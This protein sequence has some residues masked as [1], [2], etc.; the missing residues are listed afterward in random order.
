VVFSPVF[1]FPNK[2]G[3][4]M[5]T[6]TEVLSKMECDDLFA[7]QEN[8][9][10]TPP[11]ADKEWSPSA[12][13]K[14][15]AWELYTE[16]RTRI[17]TQPLAYRH[18]DEE[19]ALTSVYK[20]FDLTRTAI[21]RH[22]DCTHFAT[23]A[24]HVLNVHIRPFTAYWHKVKV[25]G[26]LGNSDTCHRF[27]R[28][29]AELQ[30]KLRLFMRLL[31]HLAEGDEFTPGTESGI[32]SAVVYP[33][34]DLGSALE[35]GI[36]DS[37]VPIHNAA[38]IDQRERDEVIARRRTYDLSAPSGAP[39]DAD[40]PKDAVGLAIS[41]GGIR[42]AT[43]SLGVVQYL[44]RKG[45]I[46]AVDFMSTVSGGGY[47][48]S[49][50]SSFLNDPKSPNDPENHD[51]G[52]DPKRHKWP[53][54][55]L[56]DV[57]S[58]AIRHLRNHSKYLAE[59]G[60][61]TYA[62]VLGQMLYGIAVNLFLTLP[63][64]LLAVVVA[65]HTLK[66]SFRAVAE[67]GTVHYPS[68]DMMAWV[69][70]VAVLLLASIVVLPVVQNTGRNLGP[71]M[72]G[73]KA[74]CSIYER[75]WCIGLFVVLLAS[76]LWDALPQ[77]YR[78]YRWLVHSAGAGNAATKALNLTPGTRGTLLATA[79]TALPFLA[80]MLQFLA[81]KTP[82]LKK[83]MTG[84]LVVSGPLFFLVAF[85]VLTDNLVVP[86]GRT[87]ALWVSLAAVTLYGGVLLNINY[88][89]PH[90]YYRRQLSRTYLRRARRNSEET[91]HVDS[92]LLSSLTGGDAK[93]AAKVKAPYHLVNC[94][95]NIPACDDPNLRGRNS[96][97]FLF[98]KHFSGSPIAGYSAT[99][100][101]EELDGHLDLGTAMATSAAA[102]APQMGTKATSRMSFLLSLLNVRLNYWAA[103]PRK[104]N[105][106]YQ[107][108]EPKRL[109]PWLTPGGMCLFKEMTGLWM[110]EKSRYLNLSDG[111][112]IE[113]LAIY[114]LLRRR[115]KFII[116]IDGEADPA[117]TFH[118]LLTLVRLAG[119]DLGV[120]IEPPLEELRR[121]E[122]GNSRSHFLLS[123]VDYEPQKKEN[124][125]SKKVGFLLYIKSSMTGNESEFL[126]KYRAEHPSFPHESTADQLFDESQFEA[127]RALGEHVAE[128]LFRPEL[129]DPIQP[130]Q[131]PLP[132]LPTVREWFQGLANSLLG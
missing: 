55:K 12:E 74:F 10:P 108:R 112:H 70:A 125:P 69:F 103:P 83:L 106:P 28:E 87:M 130:G 86:E 4:T 59:G 16:M 43:F 97:F 72:P 61:K 34:Y 116:A 82:L 104:P 60:F 67:Y 45:I 47:L 111:G 84:L 7:P 80:G 115:C 46:K 101:W 31:G 71:E 78:L 9:A 50:M 35:F 105:P 107:R 75:R 17:T 126:Q 102:A 89:S 81:K 120:K 127:Y 85:Y 88:T 29:L 42:S 113:N 39:A 90:R 57:E 33:A 66:G 65:R 18:G 14:S 53:F 36:E 5:S 99:T 1:L 41:G 8:A 62:L 25:A 118:G 32:E 44:A 129:V 20:M 114:E 38:E 96:D 131:P 63:F 40:T 93:S 21:A 48:G 54:G 77:G 123:R 2:M 13:D 30:G 132:P 56:G 98:S 95:L 79:A 100:E 76:L 23:L 27:R 37:L 49:F 121:D 94:A 119:I 58:R 24:V 73:L 22:E 26:Q 128:E 124:D 6:W 109:L 51:V 110:N 64:I 68:F 19:T 3:L 52:L 11:F 117:R 122:V 91:E 15:A 92:Q